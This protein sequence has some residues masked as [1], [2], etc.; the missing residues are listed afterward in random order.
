M[1]EKVGKKL[2]RL[3]GK[4]T[5]KEK[6]IADFL[7]GRGKLSAVE[8]R[9][10]IGGKA[11]IQVYSTMLEL[12]PFRFDLEVEDN[13]EK[14]MYLRVADARTRE[15]RKRILRIN[16]RDLEEDLKRRQ[17]ER[18]A[19]DKRINQ[20]K[21]KIEK[22]KRQLRRGKMQ[23]K[24]DEIRKVLEEDL[25]VVEGV[26]SCMLARRDIDPITPKHPKHSRAWDTLMDVGDLVFEGKPPA[27]FGVYHVVTKMLPGDDTI[28]VALTT[29][30]KK[31]GK[32]L[33][34]AKQ[35]IINIIEM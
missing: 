26:S 10:K 28:L 21:K 16:L 4:M 18:R 35:K 32:A 9:E 15:E 13:K 12:A 19:V 27:E 20:T 14:L 17:R 8:V 7:L 25:M 6:L 2:E 31:A 3:V 5:A 24:E 22:T 30:R 34:R 1:A 33:T 11:H 29:D 23:S